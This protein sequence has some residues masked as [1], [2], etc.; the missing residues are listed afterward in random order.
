[1]KAKK[2]KVPSLG[3][4]EKVRQLAANQFEITFEKGRIFQS[5][6]SIIV[7]QSKWDLYYGQDWDYS[8]TTNKY[9][10]EFCGLNTADSRKL[11][12]EGKIKM[13]DV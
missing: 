13:L 8:R 9:R 7:V 2:Y 12:E 5:Y 1:M 4:F 3:K 10:I 11:I 6:N